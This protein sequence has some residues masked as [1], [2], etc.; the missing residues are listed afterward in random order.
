MHVF[1]CLNGECIR[2]IE[3]E[4]FFFGEIGE[5]PDCGRAAETAHVD[6]GLVHR[7]VLSPEGPLG[8]WGSNSAGMDYIRRP[9][10]LADGYADKTAEGPERTGIVRGFVKCRPKL[11]RLLL[12]LTD[13]D[14]RVTCP[15]CRKVGAS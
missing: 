15:D 11:A 6:D 4:G 8:F 7:L 3:A 1:R 13:K 2:Q 14:D 9:R 12:E 5:C 10:T